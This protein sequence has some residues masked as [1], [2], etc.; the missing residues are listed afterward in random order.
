MIVIVDYID[1]KESNEIY[2]MFVQCHQTFL[3]LGT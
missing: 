1:M 2:M 3:G